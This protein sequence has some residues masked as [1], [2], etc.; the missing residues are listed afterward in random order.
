MSRSVNARY[1]LKLTER[2]LKAVG[3]ADLSEHLLHLAEKAI[4]EID[5]SD[6][7][8]FL[9]KRYG[10][11][12]M[13][14]WLRQKFGLILSIDEVVSLEP[15]DLTEAVRRTIREAY[16]KKDL[17]F[18]VEVGLAAFLPEKLRADRRPDRERLTAF[19]A[20][21]F[22]GSNIPDDVFR[23]EA[24]SKIR[25]LLLE[26]NQK[27]MP[28]LDYPEIIAKVDDAFSGARKSEAADAAE[29]SEWVKSE[30]KIEIDPKFLTGVTADVARDELLNAF[31]QKYR[32]EMHDME[33]SLVL[34][35]LDSA[36]KSHLLTMDHL[37]SVV[38]MAGYAQEDPK[39]VYKREGMKLFDDMWSGVQDRTAEAVFRME[40][41]GDEQ[42][43]SALWA[44]A[45]AMQ[46]SAQTAASVARSME[47]DRQQMSTN[48]GG[49][50]PK[51]IDPIRNL[52][53]KIGRNDPCHCGSG[54]KY[55]NCHM[56]SD[57]AK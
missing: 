37:R 15:A 8:R 49:G 14:D 53:A 29:L 27:Y 39:I 23:T 35:Q 42:V 34:E 19:A 2:E 50:E 51:K 9:E 52:G 54:K 31:D 21:R 41:I 43:Q 16:R 30:L 6:G 12:T 20:G 1:G 28:A 10:A 38:G 57:G 32:P 46:A 45:T 5:L 33:R 26:A 48:T 55:K 56:R 7:K 3:R 24:R 36:W 40:D 11:E 13:C 25:E 4:L 47:S 18:P 17:E 44:G 22:P